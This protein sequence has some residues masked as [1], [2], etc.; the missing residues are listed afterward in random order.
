MPCLPTILV[1]SSGPCSI[2]DTLSKFI[3]IRA[4]LSA[5]DNFGTGPPGVDGVPGAPGPVGEPGTPGTNG[6][7]GL[8]GNL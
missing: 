6:T 3:K 4:E 1:Y 2:K 8:P 5:F 7:D